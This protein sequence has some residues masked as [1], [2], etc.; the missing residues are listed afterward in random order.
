MPSVILR[1][2][3]PAL[4]LCWCLQQPLPVSGADTQGG[5]SNWFETVAE[6]ERLAEQQA[7]QQQHR[8]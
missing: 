5:L 8:R 6:A 4:G 3:L 1:R 7:Q 2:L